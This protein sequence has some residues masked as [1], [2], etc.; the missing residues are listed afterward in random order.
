MIDLCRFVKDHTITLGKL[1]FGNRTYFTVERPWRDNQTFVSCIPDGE[2]QMA[3]VNSP[4]FGADMW[5]IVDVPGRTHILLHV[6]NSPGNVMGCVGLGLA[7]YATLK[8]VSS[9]RNAINEFYRL[10]SG[11]TEETINITTG[12]L[13]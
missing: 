11:L 6:A 10:T 8:G 9:S 13:R 3:R 4:R 2:Y 1:T 5:E 12:A 7:V